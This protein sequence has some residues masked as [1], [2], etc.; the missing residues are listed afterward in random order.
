MIVNL[1]YTKFKASPR[2]F[3]LYVLNKPRYSCTVPVE[4]RR[5]LANG[6]AL[7]MPVATAPRSPG[8]NKELFQQA[9]NIMGKYLS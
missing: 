5:R 2:F 8:K 9:M 3:R 7:S 1:I 4:L 6:P